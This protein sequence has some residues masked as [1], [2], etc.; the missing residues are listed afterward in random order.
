MHAAASTY[1]LPRLL[2]YSRTVGL[3]LSGGTYSPDSPLLQGLYHATFPNR[4]DVLPAALAFARELA[5]NTS[6]TAVAWTKSLLWRGAESIEG[7]HILDSRA[8]S[9]L[10]SRADAAEGVQAFKE[11]RPVRFSDVLSKDLSEFV[12][13]VSCV[14]LQC[15]EPNGG[16][17]YQWT[18]VDTRQRRAKL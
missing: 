3:L 13:W 7:Q 9:D 6:Q 8:I 11:H 14:P 17:I 16:F 2:S 12:P 4:E 18:E 10:S 1:L 15:V 5:A